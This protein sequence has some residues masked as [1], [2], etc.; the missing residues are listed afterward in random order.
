MT[1]LGIII[2]YCYIPEKV[3][4]K[5][6]NSTTPLYL[7]DSAM[8]KRAVLGS[9]A[10]STRSNVLRGPANMSSGTPYL[11]LYNS[12]KRYRGYEA[13]AKW[14]MTTSTSNSGTMDDNNNE[15]TS[16][17]TVWWDCLGGHAGDGKYVMAMSTA[18]T[19]KT[20]HETIMIM[21]WELH[22]IPLQY[23]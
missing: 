22:A 20:K 16:M 3:L 13:D 17:W 15:E 5:M 14:G 12:D 8:G 19:E 18:L 7:L 10:C 6:N 1:L 4:T 11:R 9:S 21:N 2:H 23:I